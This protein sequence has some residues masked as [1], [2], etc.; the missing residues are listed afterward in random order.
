MLYLSLRSKVGRAV[1]HEHLHIAVIRRKLSE[2]SSKAMLFGYVYIP[3]KSRKFDSSLCTHDY[4]AEDWS[5]QDISLWSRIVTLQPEICPFF[6]F[7]KYLGEREEE[8]RKW[9][10]S[11]PFLHRSI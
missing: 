6:S 5:Y 1:Q 9:I 4:H 11:S 10:T 8:E 2:I 7:S 3:D